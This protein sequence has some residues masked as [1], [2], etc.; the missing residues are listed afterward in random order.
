MKFHKS[1]KFVNNKSF[2][3][4]GQ[5]LEWPWSSQA[6]LGARGHWL[7]G[8]GALPSDCEGNISNLKFLYTINLSIKRVE[9]RHFQ[10]NRVSKLFSYLGKLLEDALFQITTKMT[11]VEEGLREIPR[12]RNM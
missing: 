4:K 7:E 9:L 8:T 3:G 10:T 2:P 5:A 6:V 1:C 12:K 11:K